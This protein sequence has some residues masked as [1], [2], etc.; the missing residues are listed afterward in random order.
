MVRRGS[1]SFSAS[2]VA[3]G[4]IV[5]SK[6][7][8]KQFALE[9]EVS[10]LRHHVSVLSRRLHSTTLEK[11]VLEDIV[12]STMSGEEQP[13]DDEEVADDEAAPS[14]AGEELECATESVAG[15]GG[16]SATDD[17]AGEEED[18]RM[19][20]M[21]EDCN[22]FAI[23]LVEMEETQPPEPRL[24]HFWER[25]DFNRPAM[26]LV[27]MEET[28]PPEPLVPSYLKRVKEERGKGLEE[29]GEWPSLG[30]SGKIKEIEKGSGNTTGEERRLGSSGDE[31][32][33]IRGVIVASGASNKRKNAARRRK[34]KLLREEKEEEE[35]KSRW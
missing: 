34:R 12:A 14:V 3:K 25:E 33:V 15:E 27:E 6:A 13:L 11:Q 26:D 2:S 29:T 31:D 1:S 4:S 35:R 8:E 17:V 30:A 19:P 10:R 20:V 18:D 5:L 24:R 16:V 9:A 21:A 28:Q 7:I 32:I 22:R 23:D